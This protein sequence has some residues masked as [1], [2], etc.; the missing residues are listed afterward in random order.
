MQENTELQAKVLKSA[1]NI[2]LVDWPD[3]GLARHLLRA[4]FHVFAYSPGQYTEASIDE[5]VPHSEEG[6]SYFISS[7]E[8]DYLV[9]RKISKIPVAI[10]IVNVYR[11]EE[12]LKSIVEKHVLPLGAKVIWLHPPLISQAAKQI[13]SEHGLTLVQGDN[14]LDFI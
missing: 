4:G 5:N 6:A 8:K 9:F 1:K 10:D 3:Q 11:P 12:E 14:I 2:L 7:S 13:A